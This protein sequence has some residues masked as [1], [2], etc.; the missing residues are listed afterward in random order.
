MKKRKKQKKTDKQLTWNLVE[1]YL[2][3]ESKSGAAMA[4]F[5]TEK[6][7]EHVLDKLQY[8]GKTCE[9]KI[10]SAKNDITN[11]SDLKT[12]RIVTKRLQKELYVTITPPEAREIIK[13]YLEAI[14][15][16]TKSERNNASIF[17]KVKYKILNKAPSLKMIGIYLLL[18]FF[19]FFFGIYLVDTTEIGNQI[20]ATLVSISHLLFSWILFTILLVIGI[21]TIGVTTLFYFEKQRKKST[22]T[23]PETDPEENTL[24]D[25]HAQKDE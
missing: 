4:L 9:E 13:P 16:L 14:R 23:L 10:N 2:K 11:F 15:I 6:I 18:G 19:L 22:L 24:E 12:A 21:T 3:E 5:E 17:T 1:K 25:K 8:E 7:L 20:G